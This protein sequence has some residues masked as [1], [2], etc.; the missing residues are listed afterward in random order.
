MPT[1]LDQLIAA[2]MDA[3][4][5]DG[6]M[7]QLGTTE[8]HG[9]TLP[10]ISNAPPSLPFY[11]AHFCALHGNADFLVDGD[12]RL[13]FAETYARATDVARALVDG[14]GVKKGDRIGIAM[15]MK[16]RPSAA[17]ST[18]QKPCPS[19]AELPCAPRKRCSA[20]A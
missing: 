13:S 5:G 10:V 7:F 4:V 19:A 20:S 3:V 6:K 15:R 9:V 12:E 1:A 2:G 14:F 8:K 16:A 17:R 11:F 18:R